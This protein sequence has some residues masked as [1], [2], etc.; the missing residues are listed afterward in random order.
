M[1]PSKYEGFPNVIIE[2]MAN[3]IPVISTN[4]PSGPMEIIEDNV[5]GLLSPVEDE[6]ILSEKMLYLLKNKEF[7]EMIRS[8]AHEFVSKYLISNIMKEYESL[9]LS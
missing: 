2:A 7:S 6:K 9:Y 4:C 3:S 1:L 5:N 8:N